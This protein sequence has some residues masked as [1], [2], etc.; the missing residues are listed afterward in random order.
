MRYCGLMFI[1]RFFIYIQE[2]EDKAKAIR[3][4]I[5]QAAETIA[6]LEEQG[7]VVVGWRGGGEG[8]F[9]V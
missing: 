1:V 5:V 7:K 6:W 4:K 2:L 3:T 8:M 9:S